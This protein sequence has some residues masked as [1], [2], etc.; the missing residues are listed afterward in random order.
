M[1]NIEK[2]NIKFLPKDKI[3]QSNINNFSTISQNAIKY[4]YIIIHNIPIPIE[5]LINYSTPDVTKNIAKKNSLNEFNTNPENLS[6]FSPVTIAGTGTSINPEY[7]RDLIKEK[8]K[9][10]L[11]QNPST[12]FF[13]KIGNDML[14]GPKISINNSQLNNNNSSL[15]QFLEQNKRRNIIRENTQI[16]KVK[17]ENHIDKQIS[18]ISSLIEPAM[19]SKA[20]PSKFMINRVR[21]TNKGSSS[22]KQ[23][24]INSKYLSKESDQVTTNNS[25]NSI[26]LLPIT[27]I[28][29]L[30]NSLNSSERNIPKAYKN[31][32]HSDYNKSK[33]D[34]KNINLNFSLNLRE[35]ILLNIS[36]IVTNKKSNGKN[37]LLNHTNNNNY[38]NMNINPNS[39]Y[40]L[41]DT[42]LKENIN[43]N[44]IINYHTN[45]ILD[46]SSIS[47]IKNQT[48]FL[49]EI[50]NKNSFLNHLKM[51]EIN[52]E[53]DD[54][55]NNYSNSNIY[56]NYY[57]NSYI[58]NINKNLLFTQLRKYFQM[59]KNEFNNGINGNNLNQNE[60]LNETEFNFFMDENLNIL[61]TKLIKLQMIVLSILFVLFKNLNL[62]DYIK[63][64]IRKICSS[65]IYP[66]INFFE[67]FVVHQSQVVNDHFYL[68]NL[69]QNFRDKFK[70]IYKF[71]RMNRYFS[72]KDNIIFLNKFSDELMLMVKQFPR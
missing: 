29:S 26:N 37:S 36:N 24:N 50:T 14:K 48:N 56:D 66:L 8:K 49:K 15:N 13:S 31:T 43:S 4:Y 16:N 35:N 23:N 45:N 41:T 40:V 5:S 7:K 71:N 38:S 53:L 52:M 68:N 6:Y 69:S 2:D 60:N 33:G 58:K 1:I 30:N 59:V 34:G 54:I 44:L 22:K 9:T 18:L 67:C 64:H 19:Q 21:N 27:D 32:N 17:D 57:L 28:S 20:T 72:T 3:P 25:N 46:I 65:L 62:D 61:Y 11:I 10:Q 63:V 70:K 55:I 51:F 39:S 47:A 42:N 12:N